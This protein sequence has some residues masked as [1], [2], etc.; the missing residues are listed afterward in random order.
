LQTSVNSYYRVSATDDTGAQPVNAILYAASGWT[1][2]KITA[3]IETLRDFPWPSG[4][5]VSAQRID[6]TTA[7][8]NADLSVTPPVFS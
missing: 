4:I 8:Q 2:A 1:D 6:E 5:Q 7:T 3:L